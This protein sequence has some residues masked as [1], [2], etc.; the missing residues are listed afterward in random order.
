MYAHEGENW[1][2]RLHAAAALAGTYTA[3]AIVTLAD[4]HWLSSIPFP[5]LV[6]ASVLVPFFASFIAFVVYAPASFVLYRLM[7]RFGRRALH[8]HCLAGVLCVVLTFAGIALAAYVG[9][10]FGTAPER[11][12]DP[13][14]FAQAP[15]WQD[16]VL[17]AACV[18]S[19]AAGGTAFYYARRI[20]SSESS[21]EKA[22]GGQS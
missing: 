3:S 5:V 21:P 16:Q 12:D 8:H 15:G 2:P 14:P 13:S 17:F 6:P 10:M 19:G 11:A 1:F 18:I 9:S 22:S 20:G 4:P 7:E